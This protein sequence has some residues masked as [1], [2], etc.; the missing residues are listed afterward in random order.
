MVGLSEAALIM[1]MVYIPQIYW[2]R[3][4]VKNHGSIFIKS[5]PLSIYQSQKQREMAIEYL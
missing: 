1:R 5:F 4:E 3:R 2:E